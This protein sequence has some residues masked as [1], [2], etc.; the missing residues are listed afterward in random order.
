MYYF[1]FPRFTESM[2][3]M[4]PRNNTLMLVV[5]ILSIGA[6]GIYGILYIKRVLSE[7]RGLQITTKH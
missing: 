3:L 4:V 2:Q 7:K 1:T 6:N 5:A